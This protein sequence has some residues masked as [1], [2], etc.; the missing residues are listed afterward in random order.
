[1]HS[2]PEIILASSSPRRRELL[3]LLGLA[4]R[5]VVPEVE[6]IPLP[7][8]TP[9]AFAVRAA[10]EKAEWVAASLRPSGPRLVIGADTVVALRQQILGK[11]RDE[12]HAGEML[13]MLSGKTH[14]VITG[15]CVIAAGEPPDSFHVSTRVTMRPLTDADVAGY[16]SSGEPMDKAGAYAIQGGAAHMV[17]SI[18]GS[19]TNVVGLPLAELYE[20]IRHATGPGTRTGP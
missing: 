14:E 3:S 13:R 6:E 12:A 4:F 5:V 9:V 1:M 7:G 19:Y 10:R 20:R 16:V 17:A 18:N 11:P 15:L 8:E 2:A